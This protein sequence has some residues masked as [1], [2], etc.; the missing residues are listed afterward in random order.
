[1]VHEWKF[2]RVRRLVGTGLL[3]LAAGLAAGCVTTRTPL[4]SA[5]AGAARRNPS[6]R[7]VRVLFV[8]SHVRQRVGYDAIPK[9]QSKREALPGFDDVLSDALRELSNIGTYATF[10]DDAE[11]V[12]HPGRRAERERL[13]N[14]S[15]YTVKIRIEARKSFAGH[16][17]GL[18]ASTLTAT[19][20]PVPY[21]WSYALGA[22]ILD[23]DRHQL[24]T[25]Q[26]E[27]DRTQWVEAF[28]IFAYP[29]SPGERK[30]EE[31]Y[32]EFLHDTFRQ[33]ESEGILK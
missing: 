7:P 15:D 1:M 5:Y 32:V 28:L 2:R 17:L 16:F 31:I 8:F 20:V 27:A 24:A 33:I 29:F 22:E 9:L 3:L 14:E 6:T 4:R 23:Q 30:L 25:Y 13:M 12:N 19:L 10:T 21:T 18:I 26:R 11:D